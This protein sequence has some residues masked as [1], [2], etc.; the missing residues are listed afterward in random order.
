MK[1]NEKIVEDSFKYGQMKFEDFWNEYKK[2]VNKKHREKYDKSSFF[3]KFFL[4]KTNSLLELD[5]VKIIAKI[6][7]DNGRLQMVS[8]IN[9]KRYEK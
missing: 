8:E 4:S 6:F 2:E 9:M 7:F 1:N 5:Y 3:G